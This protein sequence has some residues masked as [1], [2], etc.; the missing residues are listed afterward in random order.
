MA[1]SR[2]KRNRTTDNPA[3]V[4]QMQNLRRSAATSPVPAKR[5][6]KQST[7]RGAKAA[8]IREFA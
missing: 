6:R 8:A 4:E 3:Y 2:T 1:K 7:R 5:V